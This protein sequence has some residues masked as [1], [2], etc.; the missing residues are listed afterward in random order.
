M[1][2]IEMFRVDP[3]NV[4]SISISMSKLRLIYLVIESAANTH[5]AHHPQKPIT[6]HVSQKKNGFHLCLNIR[7]HLTRSFNACLTHTKKTHQTPRP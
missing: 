7:D 2:R 5:I 6:K 3:Q 4:I 1:G